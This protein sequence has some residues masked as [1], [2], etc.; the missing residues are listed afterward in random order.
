MASRINPL[1]WSK[2][3]I[4][5]VDQHGSAINNLKTAPHHLKNPC[6]CSYSIWN[7]CVKTFSWCCLLS[8]NKMW[9]KLKTNK[10]TTTKKFCNCKLFILK[11]QKCNPGSLEEHAFF[12]NSKS[13]PTVHKIR[14]RFQLKLILMTI[15]HQ[16][17]LLLF[18]QI[19]I[20]VQINN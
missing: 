6:N 19:M 18:T 8:T 3:E 11:Q 17:V 4:T 1:T 5:S 14:C 20:M 12:Q 2:V 9:K 13:I 7:G 15:K 16:Q 10:K